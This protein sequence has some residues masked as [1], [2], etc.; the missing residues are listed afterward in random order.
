MHLHSISIVQPAWDHM[1][2][3]VQVAQ[4]FE[5]ENVPEPALRD[6]RKKL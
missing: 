6:I 3:I 5:Q 4:S 2:C 1:E